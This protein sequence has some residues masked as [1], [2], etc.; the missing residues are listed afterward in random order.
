LSVGG[1]NKAFDLDGVVCVQTQDPRS[2]AQRIFKVGKIDILLT[3]LTG[4][5]WAIDLALASDVPSILRVPSFEHFCS[6]PSLFATCDYHCLAGEPCTFRSDFSEMFRKASAVET[7]SEFAAKV[8]SRFYKRVA[9]VIYPYIESESHQ[10][11]KTGDRVTLVWGYPLKGLETFLSV[12]RANPS[13][14][15]MI[16]GGVQV[17]TDLRGLDV[18]V[19]GLVDD[20]REVWG[21]TRVL[22]V[23]SVVAETFGRVCIEA[24]LN[25]IPVVG[26]NRGG[27]PEAV[28]SECC[29]PLQDVEKWS[30]EVRRLCTDESYY[31]QRSLY[32][33]GYS[34]MFGLDAQVEKFLKVVGRL[35]SSPDVKL[36]VVTSLYKS[37]PFLQ[38]YFDDLARQTFKDFEVVLVCNDLTEEERQIIGRNRDGFNI[39]MVEVPREPLY[40]SWNRALD[41]A[42]GA[43]ITIA[44]VDDRHNDRAFSRYIE[45]L[46]V[47][48]NVDVV[49]NDYVRKNM[50]GAVVKLE[51]APDFDVAELK[52]RCYTGTH[53]TFRRS[54]VLLEG[55]F[56][57]SFL[58]AGDYEYWLRLATRGHKFVRIPEVLTEYL[59]R[60][61]AITYANLDTMMVETQRVQRMYG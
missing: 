22:L 5:D 23:P 27:L 40:A 45:T 25:G 20:M 42:T 28:G 51:L 61:D 59:E 57:T 60:S 11:S 14:K 38:G 10:V 55:F 56:D 31:E 26:S 47:D 46:D 21:N 48:P 6:S 49:Y 1:E 3:Q 2:Y 58:V 17:G 34:T 29:F 4:A 53:V 39:Q 18:V 44:N 37:S 7:C 13:L 43:Y 16:V 52:R 33:K 54:V 32:A 50:S 41:L 24:A 8:C 19:L 15:Y 30:A 36:S 9:D 35:L 12:A